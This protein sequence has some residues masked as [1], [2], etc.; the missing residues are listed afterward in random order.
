M[1]SY[2]Y[3]GYLN[4]LIYTFL[5]VLLGKIY[6]CVIRSTVLKHCCKVKRVQLV[7]V[8]VQLSSVVKLMLG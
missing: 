1:T 7:T 2:G 4:K 3:L 6:K 8:L 5:E